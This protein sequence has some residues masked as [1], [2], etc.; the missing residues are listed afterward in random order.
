[1]TAL[2]VAASPSHRAFATDIMLESTGAFLT[3]AVLYCYL[4]AV[5]DTTPSAG[6]WLGLALTAL[7]LEK[8]NYWLLAVIAVTAC[9]VAENRRTIVD[10]WRR[11]VT[12]LNGRGIVQAEVRQPLNYLLAMVLVLVGAVL[13]HGDRP[14]LVGRA[15]VSL[16]PPHNIVQVA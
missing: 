14:F 12:S 2:F 3:L 7:F 5:Q 1:A 9:T 13:A 10:A 6:R 8:Y 16:F 15:S 11:A 4:V